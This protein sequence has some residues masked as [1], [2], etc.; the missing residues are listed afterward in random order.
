MVSAVVFFF[1]RKS[2][3]CRHLTEIVLGKPANQ[4]AAGQQSVSPAWHHISAICFD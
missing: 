3:F 1:K 4:I 2:Y